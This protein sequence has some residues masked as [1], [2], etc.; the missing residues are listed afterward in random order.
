MLPEF[1]PP[2]DS[3]ALR[4]D[5]GAALDGRLDVAE[6]L[7]RREEAYPRQRSGRAAPPPRVDVVA[8][9]SDTATVLEVRAH[10]RPGLLHRIGSALAARRSTSA[11]RG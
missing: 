10:D 4:E 2:P 1:G 11:R 3:A 9:A 6:R 8:G 5:V 7:R